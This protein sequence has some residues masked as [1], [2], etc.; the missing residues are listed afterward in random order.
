MV[1]IIFIVPLVIW[2]SEQDQVPC[3]TFILFYPHRFQPLGS[4]GI[5]IFFCDEFL[6]L[7]DK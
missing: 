6:P 3:N 2:L 4:I 5:K 1:K 7:D